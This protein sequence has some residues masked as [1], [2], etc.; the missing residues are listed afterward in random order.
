MTLVPAPVP[1]AE[2]PAAQD[3]YRLRREGIGHIEQTGSDEWTDYNTHDPG[4]S[5]LEALAYA[6]TELAYRTGFPIEDILASAASRRI[7]R[8]TPIPTRP[9]TRP[10]RSSPSTRPRPRTSGGC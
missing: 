6:I 5:I 9:S 3:F 7:G 8:Q 2:L 10:A 4:I 1:P